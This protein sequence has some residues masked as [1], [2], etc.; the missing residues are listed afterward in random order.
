MEMDK[1]QQQASLT[2]QNRSKGGDGRLIPLLG[3]AGEV[4]TLLEEYKKHLRDGDAH[5]LF[6]DHIAEELGDVLWYLSNIATKFDLKLSE[7]AQANLKKTQS[8]WAS[9]SV[10]QPAGEKLLDADYPPEYQFPRQFEVEFKDIEVDGLT[11]T[12]MYLRDKEENSQV[13]DS[14]TDNAHTTDNYRFH[15]VFHLAFVAVLGWSPVIRKLLDCKRREPKKIDEVEDG[16]RAA[17]I[18][19][20]L[21]AFIFNYA[22]KHNFLDGVNSVDFSILKTIKELVAGL[23]VSRRNYADWENAI[24]QA[25]AIFRLLRDDIGL[26]IVSVD[27]NKRVIDFRSVTDKKP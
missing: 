11:K 19:E 6:G 17:V 14:L 1:Y 20:A 23:E 18:D 8:R 25:C 2:D 16:G 21:V 24:I 22:E 27:M 10:A 5:K 4:G 7:I 3:I 26:G 12:A 9:T 15:D 13:G